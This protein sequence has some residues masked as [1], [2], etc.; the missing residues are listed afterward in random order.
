[1]SEELEMKKIIF[2][3]LPLILM[4]TSCIMGAK[5]KTTF[6]EE[7]KTSFYVP[8]LVDYSAYLYISRDLLTN[9]CN[10]RM[11]V[12]DIQDTEDDVLN[13]RRVKIG[14]TAH[15]LEFET[16]PG[17]HVKKIDRVYEEFDGIKNTVR[18]HAEI[19]DIPLTDQ[20]VDI[21]NEMINDREPITVIFVGDKEVTKELPTREKSA[22]DMMLKKYMELLYLY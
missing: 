11:K 5:F 8:T 13:Y 4:L 21:F 14:T 17:D 6:D 20:Q 9:E 15:S 12:K 2:I 7:S 3:C 19:A 18:K 22:I 10:M 16:F 1:M